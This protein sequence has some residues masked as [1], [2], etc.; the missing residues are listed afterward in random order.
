MLNRFGLT[1]AHKHF[2]LADDEVL[3]ENTDEGSRTQEII[4]KKKD[5]IVGDRIS[6]QFMFVEDSR[7]VVSTMECIQVTNGHYT[8]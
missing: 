4:V 8:N 1:L 6:T 2:D 3:V 7:V 5:D